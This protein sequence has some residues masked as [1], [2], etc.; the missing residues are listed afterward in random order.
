MENLGD[1]PQD[2]NDQEEIS[3][4]DQKR[5]KNVN[6]ALSFDRTVLCMD[7]LV[8]LD[9]LSEGFGEHTSVFTSLPDISE[10]PEIFHSYMVK[11]YKEWF[12]STLCKI[13][14]KLAVGSYLILLQSDVR[15]TNLDGDLFEWMDKSYL[16]SQAAQQC[17]LTMVWHKLVLCNKTMEKRSAGRPSYSHLLCYVKNGCTGLCRPENALLRNISNTTWILP[18]GCPPFSHR[19]S[20]FAVP[21][22][23]HRGEMLWVR[24]IGL[25][26]CYAGIAFLRDIAHA[27]RVID[28]FTGVGTVL[29]MANALGMTALGV[30]I[31]PKRC[32]KARQLEITEEHLNMVSHLVRRITLNEVEE[33]KKK[34][35]TAESAAV[36]SK[37]AT[38]DDSLSSNNNSNNS[39]NDDASSGTV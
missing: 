4:S 19:S 34:R 1:S 22:I 21:D 32:R 5:K 16:A 15:L 3:N 10:M 39:S 31:S 9:S 33:R 37:Q 24:G 13:M 28:P 20:H 8:W 25:D 18:C 35:E 38:R 27:K 14:S 26:C 36:A 6:K 12:V 30:E 29:A 2:H 7:A 23:F 17:G 11:E